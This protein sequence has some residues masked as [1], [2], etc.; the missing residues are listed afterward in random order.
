MS[1]V[2]KKPSKQRKMIYEAPAHQVRK[3]LT[4][5]LSDELRKSQERRSYPVRKGDTV[6]ILRGD[7]AGIEGK[8]NDIDARRQRLFVEG[9]QREKTSGTSANVSVN[10]SKVMITKLNL[11][12][13]WRAESVK[14]SRAKPT[15]AGTV[16]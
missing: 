5:P 8:I 16:A 7:F 9:V 14:L 10:S 1:P 6:K 2:A 12:D 3:R 13:K 4:A 15:T 11:D